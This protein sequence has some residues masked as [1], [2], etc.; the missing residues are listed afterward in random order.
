MTSTYW[1]IA[2]V[3]LVVIEAATLALTTVWF[4]G[5]AIAAFLLS[6]A[7]AGTN[8]QL[9]VFAVVSFV[10]LF[11]TR[12][13]AM[14]HVNSHAT[15]TNADSLIG[16]QARVTEEINNLSGTGSAVINGL[17]WTARSEK[18]DSVYPVDAVVEICAIRGVKLIV[19]N[20]QEV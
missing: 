17:E 7:G 3:I 15:K 8:A 14:R 18:D 5:G 1:L 19:K 11:F 20:V 6:L 4:A 10:L 2:F 13:W 16:R 9:S 12:P